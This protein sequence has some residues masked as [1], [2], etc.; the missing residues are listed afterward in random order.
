MQKLDAQWLANFILKKIE[1]L[2]LDLSEIIA[3]C[4]DGANV[5]S[6]QATGV[7]AHIVEKIPHAF[8]VHCHAHR[9]NLVLINCVKN[10]ED[11]ADFFSTMQTLYTF[12]SNSKPRL[13]LF[14][15]SQKELGQEVLELE[16][17]QI[18]VTTR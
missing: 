15:K 2:G 14:I 4:Y 18:T 3:E 7:Q 16:R 6:G 17:S 5:M 8:Y 1:E 9:L 11:Y 12:I 13:E 10:L